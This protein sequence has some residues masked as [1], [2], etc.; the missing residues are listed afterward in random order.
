LWT[1]THL[2]EFSRCKVN[3]LLLRF[4]ALLLAFSTLLLAVSTLAE[5]RELLCHLL[6]SSSEI[7][8]LAGDARDVVS[9]CDVR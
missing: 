9:V 2:G 5:Q 7:G 6:D 4:R 3:S 8:Q 1:V